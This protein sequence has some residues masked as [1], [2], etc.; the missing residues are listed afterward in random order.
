MCKRQIYDEPSYFNDK[1]LEQFS[2]I[3][4]IWQ[5][6]FNKYEKEIIAEIKNDVAH[7]FKNNKIFH[8]Q[9]IIKEYKTKIKVKFVIYSDIDFK[10]QVL[11]WIPFIRILKPEGYKEYLVELLEEGLEFQMKLL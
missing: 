7:Y 10:I 2:E 9:E 4:T 5:I 3:N 1:I 6:S 8:N 11:P